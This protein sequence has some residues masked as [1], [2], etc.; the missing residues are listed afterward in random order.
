MALACGF[1]SGPGDP[2]LHQYC[3]IHEYQHV[4]SKGGHL[5]DRHHRFHVRWASV[6]G[7]GRGHRDVGESPGE[8]SAG[9]GTRER[10]TEPTAITQNSACRTRIAVDSNELHAILSYTLEP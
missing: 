1:L 7:A 5:Y 10:N 4:L 8:R 6:V 3:R 2:L 9:I